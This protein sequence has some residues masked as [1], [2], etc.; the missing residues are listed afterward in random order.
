MAHEE[1]NLNSV[2]AELE[3][4][5][6]AGHA[7]AS[8][9][10]QGAQR[11]A[12]RLRGQRDNSYVHQ[13]D[14][15]PGRKTYDDWLSDLFFQ[16][17]NAH[18]REELLR[19]FSERFAEVWASVTDKKRMEE[20]DERRPMQ[21]VVPC[22]M[23]LE[24]EADGEG[25]ATFRGLRQSG[26]S[27][28]NWAEFQSA[29]L[30][31]T[32][33]PLLE[34]VL[35]HRQPVE[36]WYLGFLNSDSYGGVFD[37][38]LPGGRRRHLWVQALPL[39]D[40]GESRGVF[41][42]YPSRGDL[43][44][45]KPPGNATYDWRMLRF[46]GIAY[47]LLERQIKNLAA[48]VEAS[49]RDM[50][51]LL[52]PG[53]M[54]HELGFIAASIANM[55]ERLADD[56]ACVDAEYE[57]PALTAQLE[58]SRDIARLGERLRYV[59]HAFNRLDRRGAV[60]QTLLAVPVE[61]CRTLLA[62]R[63]DKAKVGFFVEQ[64]VEL[65]PGVQTDITLV[66]HALLNV[67]N[68]AIYAIEEEIGRKDGQT[69]AIHIRQARGLPENM[70]GLDIANDGPPIPAEAQPRIFQRGYTTRREGHGQGLF[71]VLL[72][73]QYLGGD[74]RLLSADELP[75][76]CRAGFRFTLLKHHD[77]QREIGNDYATG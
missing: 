12:E 69:R 10:R 2:I 33:D 37:T 75:S 70:I 13:S 3:R 49:R 5:A 55:S 8:A 42:I 6:D 60:E 50:I 66:T 17:E 62:C 51:N 67:C 59:T 14:Q 30:W 27:G 26:L 41:L 46:L 64:A 61:E 63:L 45:P 39:V 11:L 28:R 29:R 58:R 25:Q 48:Y 24:A 68:N 77:A 44:A 38:L 18:P 71:L 57:L 53:L 72:I 1:L 4:L 34:R 54:H 20:K 73:A 52:A 32:Q 7:S 16:V 56:L 21:P 43:F 74:V 36:M 47:R 22:L 40:R 15:T 35:L 19:V 23:I 76:G 65:A 9:L 31:H